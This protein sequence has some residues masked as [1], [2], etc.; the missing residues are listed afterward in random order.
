MLARR[1]GRADLSLQVGRVQRSFLHVV[2]IR[3]VRDETVGPIKRRAPGHFFG[4]PQHALGARSSQTWKHRY[5]ALYPVAR[6]LWH[7]AVML[8]PVMCNVLAVPGKQFIATN[9]G[10]KHGG[11]LASFAAYQVSGD[12]RWIGDR[13]VHVPDETR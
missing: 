12:D 3:A 6:G 10:E 1:V 8:R 2:Q 11:L 9:S 5:D 13:L 7:A 4:Q